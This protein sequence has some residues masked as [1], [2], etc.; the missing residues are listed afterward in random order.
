NATRYEVG[1][2]E[3]LTADRVLSERI[4]GAVGDQ[5][6]RIEGFRFAPDD[7][8]P[9][10]WTEVFVRGQFAGVAR[11]IGRRPGPIYQLIEDLYAETVDEIAQ[12]ITIVDVPD[13]IS[14]ALGTARKGCNVEVQRT[15]RLSNGDIAEVA[16]NIYP[17]ERFHL[18]MSMRRSRD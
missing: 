4:G 15:Y 3:M 7:E 10:C 1:S 2:D 11:L 5:W 17:A 16:R 8:R 6:L 13:E 12:T 18:A 14:N 9:V